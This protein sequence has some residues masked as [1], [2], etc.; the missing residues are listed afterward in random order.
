MSP[1]RKNII[2]DDA[3]AMVKILNR[4]FGYKEYK[5]IYQR[6]MDIHGLE[7]ESHFIEIFFHGGKDGNHR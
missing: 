2:R 3:E 4:K 1:K 6:L 7:F 5:T